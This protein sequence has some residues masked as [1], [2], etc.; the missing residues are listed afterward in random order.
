MRD[1]FAFE[2]VTPERKV[3]SATALECVVPGI[4]GSF[5]VLPDHAPLLTRL[6]VGELSY[7]DATGWH[8]L[9]AADGMVEVL[10]DRV[11]IIASLCER[12][13]E[14]DIERAREAKRRAEEAMKL[15]AKVSD[16]DMMMIELSLKKALT[17]LH[18]A[19]RRPKP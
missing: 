6:G 15:A 10:P 19:D 16:Q 11:T 18:V 3:L 13:G 12:A 9:S 4:E 2:V 5:G 8:Y 7:R 17:R 14:I 1:A